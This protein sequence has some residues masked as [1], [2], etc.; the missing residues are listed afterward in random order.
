MY[1]LNNLVHLRVSKPGFRWHALN[2]GL[3]GLRFKTSTCLEPCLWFQLFSR[4]WPKISVIYRNWTQFSVCFITCCFRFFLAFSIPLCLRS[5][6]LSAGP[7]LARGFG[8]QSFSGFGCHRT[9]PF[10]LDLGLASGCGVKSAWSTGSWSRIALP[11]LRSLIRP[12][13]MGLDLI[14]QRYMSCGNQWKNDSVNR[15]TQ[16]NHTL[17]VI[18]KLFKVNKFA[19]TYWTMIAKTNTLY[20]I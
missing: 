18:K 8:P 19:N 6:K 11:G 9:K 13:L 1:S 14:Q 2:H 5:S 16:Q 15:Q 7:C 20:V 10:C 12:S 17:S 3:H 4:K